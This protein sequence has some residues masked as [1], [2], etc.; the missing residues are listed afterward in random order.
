MNRLGKIVG[1][2]LAIAGFCVQT[3]A[4][5]PIGGRV[6]DWQGRPVDGAEVAVYQKYRENQ[7]QY[8]RLAGPVVRTDERGCFALE[9]DIRSQYDTF[10]V[11]RKEG[12]A[13]AWDGLNYGGNAKVEGRF[14][15]VLERPAELTGVVVDHAGKPVADARVWALPKTSY[16]SRLYQRPMVAPEEWF[17]TQSDADGRFRFVSFAGDVN[18][19]FRVTAPSRSV[20]YEFTTRYQNSCGFEVGR[21]DIRLVLPQEGKV[22]GQTVDSRTGQPV[23]NVRLVIRANKERE[24]IA[25]LYI[26]HCTQSDAEGHFEFPGVPAGKHLVEVFVASDDTA[27]WTGTP[28]EIET[29]AP[30]ARTGVEVAIS[31]G[32][33]IEVAARNARTGKPLSRIATNASQ[34][35]PL[36]W[37][38]TVTDAE[39][40]A[41]L[42]VRPGEFDVAAWQTGFVTW[43][44]P[45][46]VRVAEGQTVRLEAQLEPGPRLSGIVRD[47]SGNAVEGAF[48]K[49]HPWGDECYSDEA[50]RFSVGYDAARGTQG[51]CMMAL[52]AR[53]NRAAVA[54]LRDPN[55]PLTLTLKPAVQVTGHIAD[56]NGA[57]IPAARVALSVAVTNRL[58]NLGP[59]TLT[60]ADGRFHLMAVAPL[61]DVF[62]YRISVHAPDYGPKTYDK[63][64]VGGDPGATCDLGTITL[65]PANAAVSGVVVDA[66]GIPAPRIPIFLGRG[67][68]GPRQPRKSTATNAEGRFCLTRICEGP[69]HLQANFRSSPGGSAGT[70]A[71]TGHSD[72]RI[73][74]PGSLSQPK[75]LLE[76]ALPALSKI[77]PALP[78]DAGQDDALLVCFFDM[79]QRP[80]RH[81]VRHLA[82]KANQLKDKKISMIALQA[83]P[84][85]AQA[86][87]D[88]A[89][90]Q[91]VPFPVVATTADQTTLRL[92][93]GVQSLPWLILTDA[94]QIVR[95][96]GFAPSE[97]DG[98]IEDLKGSRTRRKYGTT[99][100]WSYGR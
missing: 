26:P 5:L 72:V 12:L 70:T 16:H 1:S 76:K 34:R 19:D 80:S 96:E 98:K 23:P 36:I 85:K 71:R 56:P 54:Q 29:P 58:S 97:L 21:T 99:G 30:A 18:C 84:C 73:V 67:R 24:D 28:V 86:L 87:A 94:Q 69:L 77:A 42:R 37:A 49:P 10:I 8:G 4:A 41:R 88:W 3:S 95:A 11:A 47:R 9:A 46:P 68:D 13:L 31:K 65:P 61:A 33:V 93:W 15:L 59:E 17:T 7:K 60:D 75:S 6:V 48:I 57:P 25:N 66:D 100:S 82:Q 45:G 20:T 35:E 90:D 44:A 32:G 50:G 74:L 64:S 38:I 89:E 2:M 79:N 81:C 53:N 91:K 62:D 40:T 51:A 52:D 55:E 14:L 39:G 92:D 78:S 83:A 22:T 27:D 43:H 63:V